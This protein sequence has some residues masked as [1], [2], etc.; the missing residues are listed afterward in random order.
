ML[1]LVLDWSAFVVL[2]LSS[3]RIAES[4]RP[5]FDPLHTKAFE[6]EDEPEHEHEN[7]ATERKPETRLATVP[8]ERYSLL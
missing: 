8:N 7:A 5:S 1:V 4:S 2:M 3:S 6:H